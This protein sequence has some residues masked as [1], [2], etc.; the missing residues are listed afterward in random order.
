MYNIS[1]KSNGYILY[2]PG[3]V[4]QP[5]DRIPLAAYGILDLVENSWQQLR[6]AYDIRATQ[7]RMIMEQL[8]EELIMRLSY[9]M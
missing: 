1:L 5:R 8:P 4:G 6:V 9:G 7:D 2:N 3:S